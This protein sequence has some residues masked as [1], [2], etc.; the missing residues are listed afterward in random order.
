MSYNLVIEME[1]L[2][3]AFDID[4]WYQE[5]GFMQELEPILDRTLTWIS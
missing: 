4:Q 1:S 2:A 5:D 3:H